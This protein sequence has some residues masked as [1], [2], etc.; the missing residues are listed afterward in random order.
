MTIN[1]IE[2]FYDR[3]MKNIYE[4]LRFLSSVYILFFSA[5]ISG[6]TAVLI[7]SA[8]ISTFL[9]GRI[10]LIGS[11]VTTFLYSAFYQ[12]MLMHW[13]W[14]K[15]GWMYEFTL[16]GQ[17]VPVKDHGGSLVIHL[18]SGILGVIGN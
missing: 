8:Q 6:F 16:Q 9:V 14:N 15:N 7:S 5:I 12:A 2:P 13:I 11:F 4:C 10:H 1:I 18:P 3:S 17:I